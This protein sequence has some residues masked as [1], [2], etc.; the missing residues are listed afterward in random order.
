M[1]NPLVFL[2]DFIVPLLVGLAAV[3]ALGPVRGTLVGGLLTIFLVYLLFYF[4]VSDG[5]GV[6]RSAIARSYMA[7]E[8]ILWIPFFLLGTALGGWLH[9]R[10]GKGR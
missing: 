8:A 7:D 1:N 6:S 3:R 9:Q 2:A 10:R 5:P 4:Q